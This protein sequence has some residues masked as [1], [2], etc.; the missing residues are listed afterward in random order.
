L[1][2]NNPFDWLVT[3]TT[4][5]VIPIANGNAQNGNDVR[6]WLHSVGAGAYA[7]AFVAQDISLDVV[8]LLSDAHLREL[9]V[10]TLGARLR[11]LAAARLLPHPSAT[12]PV[13]STASSSP[14]SPSSSRRSFE[15]VPSPSPSPSSS[16]SS[17]AS[18]AALLSLANGITNGSSS[19]NN[20]AV[21][22]ASGTASTAS[23]DLFG[24]VDALLSAIQNLHTSLAKT[25]PDDNKV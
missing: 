23:G 2:L 25:Q 24:A 21:G 12:S 16:S 20:A 10:A 1:V 5:V 13:S 3:A 6:V 17:A 18:T 11:L 8:P 4:A 19:L 9:G 7:D 14:S 15:A 22:N